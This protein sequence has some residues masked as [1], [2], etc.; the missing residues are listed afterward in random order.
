MD[1]Y[2]LRPSPSVEAFLDRIADRAEHLAFGLFF[3]RLV[4]SPGGN[5]RRE[6]AHHGPRR[7]LHFSYYV[8]EN[9][10]TIFVMM[11]YQE[12]PGEPRERD[13]A[14][15]AEFLRAIQRLEQDNG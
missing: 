15:E 9:L 10:Q 13:L 11:A 1:I 5:G 8:S 2:D 3:R 12:R 7:T 6:F 4:Q 14:L